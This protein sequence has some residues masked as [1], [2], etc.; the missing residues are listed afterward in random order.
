[1][2]EVSV[3]YSEKIALDE[4]ISTDSNYSRFDSF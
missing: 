1:M 3:L 2:F 4:L